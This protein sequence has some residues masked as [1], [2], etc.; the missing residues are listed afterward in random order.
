MQLREVRRPLLLV[1]LPILGLVLVGL[2]WLWRTGEQPADGPVSATAPVATPESP[3]EP[4]MTTASPTAATQQ[5]ALWVQVDEAA[6]PV[7]PPYAAEWSTEDRAL[8]RISDVASSY[9]RVGDRLTLPLPQLSETYEPLIEEIDEAV[10]SRAL[11]GKIDGDDGRRWRYV[12]TIGP[13]SVFAFIDT[14]R[15]PYELVANREHGWLLPSSSMMAGWDFSKSDIILPQR[16]RG[17]GR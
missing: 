13:T 2:V 14:P 9:W 16:D 3:P 12:V 1:G 7:P 15:G 8:V 5:D 11:L 10:G 4:P 17:T 6:V